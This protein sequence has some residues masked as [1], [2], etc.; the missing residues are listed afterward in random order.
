MSRGRRGGL[1]VAVTGA[2]GEQSGHAGPFPPLA[3]DPPAANPPPGA[4]YSCGGVIR[5]RR[6]ALQAL[7]KSRRASNSRRH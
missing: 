6:W 2:P 1:G 5:A 4:L 3:H 7:S